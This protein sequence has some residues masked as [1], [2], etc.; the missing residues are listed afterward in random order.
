MINLKT[1]KT[2]KNLKSDF[3]LFIK[4]SSKFKIVDIR[5]FFNDI[6]YKF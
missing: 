2:K 6:K 3:F 5:K 4:L 1:F